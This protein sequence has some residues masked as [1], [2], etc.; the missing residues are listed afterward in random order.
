MSDKNLEI[1]EDT[2][3]AVATILG[4]DL[5]GRIAFDAADVAADAE[6]ACIA[7]LAGHG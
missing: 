1:G 7:V 6:A 3:V 2:G 5:D 4:S